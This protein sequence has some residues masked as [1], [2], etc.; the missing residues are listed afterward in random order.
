[1][2]DDFDYDGD[3][4]DED[5][6]PTGRFSGSDPTP[7]E[8]ESGDEVEKRE[9]GPLKPGSAGHRVLLAFEDGRRRTSYDASRIA[10]GDW[11]AKRREA[12]RL[13]KRGFLRKDGVLPNLAP[14]GRPHVDAFVIT[15]IGR[16]DIDR[17]RKLGHG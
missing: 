8:K 13:E 12:E 7:T 9:R 17:L 5:F 3:E 6:V 14:S 4:D 15:A 2:S 11:H 16:L 10:C 1:M